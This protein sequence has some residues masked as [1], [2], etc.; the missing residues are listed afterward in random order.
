M[1]RPVYRHHDSIGNNPIDMVLEP[2]SCSYRRRNSPTP[3]R[4]PGKSDQRT[5]VQPIH[6]GAL[7]F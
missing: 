3:E 2:D 7:D 1:V 6:C 5:S 4:L